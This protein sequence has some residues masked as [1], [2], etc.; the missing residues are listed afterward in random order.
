[1]TL[2]QAIRYTPDVETQTPDEAETVAGL[3][4][5]FDKILNRTAKDYGHAVRAVHA[6]AHGILAGTLFI[7]PGLAPELAQGLFAAPGEHAVLMRFSTN[8]G[9]IL[10]DA[11]SVPRGLAIKVQNVSGEFLP[12][13]EGKT[14]D[15]VFINGPVFLA[16]TARQFLG[17]LKL[18][19]GTTD[20]A[21]GAKKFGSAILRGLNRTLSAIGVQSTIVQSLGGAPNT[22]PLGETYFST[23]PFRFGEYMAKFSLV[24][25]S[26]G[27]AQLRGATIN[28]SGRPDALREEIRK[29]AAKGDMRWEFRVQL[30]RDLDSQ[31]IEDS[32]VE[33]KQAQSPFQTV[34]T[35]TAP[36]QD[37]WDEAR[38]EAV[39]ERMRFSV[40]TGLL[41]H[42]PLGN[43]NRA[44]RDPYRHSASFRAARNPCP[45]GETSAA[46]EGRPPPPE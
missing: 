22:H 13:S 8:P 4:A 19:A 17:N 25:V 2:P 10:D 36:A 30:C 42:Q 27:L 1:M 18:L 44:R 29:T 45:I 11:I 16:K 12:D 32:T 31:P 14:Q 43:I 37:S 24:P 5:T 26:P 3:N 40:W 46:S 39:N 38:V 20:R 35:L 6:K 41:A 21:Q 28:T 9:D 23:T 7:E 34:A 33:W 15:F